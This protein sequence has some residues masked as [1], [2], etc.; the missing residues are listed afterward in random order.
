MNIPVVRRILKEDL[1]KTGPVPAWV[2]ALLSPLNEFI[3]QVALALRNNLTLPENMSGKLFSTKFTHNVELIINPG[4]TQKILGVIPL[5]FG[6][7]SLVSFSWS[8]KQ[9]GGL[10]VTFG[11]G[12]GGTTQD[13]CTIFIFYGV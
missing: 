13:T 8:K 6:T 1:Q 9:E 11:F 2:D 5:G 4:T 7:Q 10:G 12:A 3:D